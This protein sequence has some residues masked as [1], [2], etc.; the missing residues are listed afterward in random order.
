MSDKSPAARPPAP[1]GRI[2]AALGFRWIMPIGTIPLPFHPW[3]AR[4][5]P[6]F[7]VGLIAHRL[8]LV[9]AGDGGGVTWWALLIAAG[10]LAIPMTI[11]IVSWLAMAFRVPLL[12][13]VLIGGA[14]VLMAVDAAIGALP[15]WAGAVPAAW[16]G[17][18]LAQ[19]FGGPLYLRRLEAANAAFER[20]QPGKRLLIVERDRVA[21][22]YANRLSFEYALARVA[23]EPDLRGR[24]TKLPERTY[25][26]MSPDD[27]PSVSERIERLQPKGWVVIGER[28]AAPGIADPGD[29]P[30]IRIRMR[31]HRAPLWLIGGRREALEIDDGRS[32]RRLV[33]GEAA[34]TGRW[35]LFTCFYWLSIF[36]GRSQWFAGFAREK[37]VNL[38]STRFWDL[39]PR[40]FEPLAEAK[41]PPYA[42][43]APLLAALDALAAEAREDGDELLVKLLRLDPDLP[44]VWPMHVQESELASG[45]G[46][47]LCDCLA[48]AKAAKY[49][50][51]ARMSAQLIAALPAVE[52]R[53]L[54][55]RLLVLLNSKEL[56]F[57]L[58][59]SDD[60]DIVEAPES[61]RRKHVIGGLRLLRSV[62]KLYERL[63][64]LGEAA[65]PLVMALGET[66]R[67]PAPLVEARRLL[68]SG[69]ISAD[70]P[71]S[72]S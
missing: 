43:A 25:H 12:Q 69:E 9:A 24:S 16:I 49:E 33:G 5:L 67:W 56:A 32:V 46:P 54:A 31:R 44:V 4:L 28:V 29:R 6:F 48:A 1:F 64:E 68:D 36:G 60:P 13:S 39:A 63:G 66:G 14:V 59:G 19:R 11:P 7:I 58:L 41:P 17:L 23:A 71:S 15:G 27:W 38:G 53:A 22:D 35:P 45:R 30:P 37:P 40:V 72:D 52:Y 55:D 50:Q 34:L 18:F 3:L 51:A 70:A 2:G 42:D 20:V 61:E 10:L 21:T 47:E 26:R 65:R 8:V 62:P 57:R